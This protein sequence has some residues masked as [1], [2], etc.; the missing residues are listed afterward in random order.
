MLFRSAL[1]GDADALAAACGGR[2]ARDTDEVAAAIAA[3][4][5]P[6]LVKGSRAHA[7]ER[8]LPDAV[9]RQLGFH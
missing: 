2:V 5:G 1:G 3:W 8:A 6:V 4:S 9:R 7:L